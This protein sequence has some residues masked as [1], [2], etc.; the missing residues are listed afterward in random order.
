[1]DG[2]IEWHGQVLGSGSYFGLRALSGWLDLPGQRGSNPPLPQRHGAY[3]GRKLSSERYV[4]FDFLT[5]RVN[6]AGFAAAVDTLR[7]ITSPDEDPQE[8][9]LVIRLDG[10]SWR[11]EARVIRREIPTDK[12]YALGRTAGSIQWEATDPRI[13]SVEELTTSA[14]LAAPAGSGLDFSGGGLSFASGGL[15]FGSGVT[16]GRIT[17]TALGH[18]PTWP[19]LE[20]LGPVIGPLVA[21]PGDRQLRFDPTFTVLAGQQVVIDTRPSLRTVEIMPAGADTGANVKS[22][23]WTKQWTPLLPNVPTEI[24][25]SVQSSADYNG[26]TTL[27]AFW[28]HAKH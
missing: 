18:V 22:R 3:P 19:R 12:H 15:D 8:E 5:K 17:A 20:I 13:Y 16:G 28:R 10:E 21:F 6:R 7:R 11:C 23:L 4:T 2:Q 26:T 27:S 25:Y 14:H 24:R 1:M 9:P